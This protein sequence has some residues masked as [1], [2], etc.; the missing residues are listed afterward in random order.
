MA[1]S[2]D[3]YT[4][5]PSHY[6]TP[7]LP[8]PSQSSHASIPALDSDTEI[9]AHLHNT[10]SPPQVRNRFLDNS[11]TLSF[12]RNIRAWRN[13]IVFDYGVIAGI[14]SSAFSEPV[15]RLL[16]SEEAP[17]LPP[18]AYTQLALQL[19]WY[20]SRR[21]L[22]ATYET[23]LTRMFNA[24]L[25]GCVHICFLLGLSLEFKSHRFPEKHTHPLFTD[26]LFSRSQEWKLSTSGLSASDQFRGTG[27]EDRY[28]INFDQV[29][30]G[31]HS[32]PPHQILRRVQTI[33]STN[34]F[35]QHIAD[36]VRD[37]RV[38]CEAGELELKDR[39]KKSVDGVGTRVHAR[40][41]A[42]WH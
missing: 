4:A 42:W 32:T 28:G 20:R 19:A 38:I 26:P 39:T 24:G 11:L 13:G 2:L 22:I 6:P 1:L 8:S 36:A 12:E 5:M 34:K 15:A 33:I 10:R 7:T 23:A 30:R 17:R 29:D 14:D 35:K 31:S 3:H 18:D 25:T 21:F 27:W 41:L 9:Y 37:M 16:T 40:L